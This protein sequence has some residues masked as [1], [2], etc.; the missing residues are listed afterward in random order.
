MCRNRGDIMK[1]T[2]GFTLVELMVVVAIIAIL[3]AIAIPSYLRYSYRS[4][5]EDGQELLLR[6]ASAQERFYSTMNRYGSL[7]EVGFT[8]TTSSQNYYT[9][10]LPAA[11]GTSL[12]AFT[13][14][15]VP[16]GSQAKDVCGTLSINSVGIKLPALT[17]T[18]HN[19]NGNC[20]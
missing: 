2:R 15:A 16:Q 18:A 8:N 13:A 10:D 9:A 6:I 11:A 4:R 17:D 3:A 7:A 1:R 12:Q 14:E 19:S 5:R 20:W